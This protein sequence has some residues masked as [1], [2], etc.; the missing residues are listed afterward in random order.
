MTCFHFIFLVLTLIADGK[1]PA[2]SNETVQLKAEIDAQGNKV[3]E[4]KAANASKVI[5]HQLF[6]CSGLCYFRSIIGFRKMANTCAS[7]RSFFARCSAILH[8]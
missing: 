3:R 8:L 6:C 5:R 1:L 2:D 7:R 4:A